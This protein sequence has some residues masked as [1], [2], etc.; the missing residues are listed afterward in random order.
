MLQEKTHLQQLPG[1]SNVVRYNRPQTETLTLWYSNMATENPPFS[2][3]IFALD[4]LFWSISQP[5]IFDFHGIPRGYMSKSCLKQVH[6][7]MYRMP[8]SGESKIIAIPQAPPTMPFA[9]DDPPYCIGNAVGSHHASQ[10]AKFHSAVSNRYCKA[11]VAA[12]LE[13]HRFALH[14][15]TSFL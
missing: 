12:K 6:G 4:C 7:N 15:R 13:R 3:M 2:S 11:S 5:A 14:F 1:I 9:T 10:P 8:P